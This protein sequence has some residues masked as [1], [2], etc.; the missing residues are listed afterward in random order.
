MFLKVAAK[1]AGVELTG[2]EYEAMQKS[3]KAEI[4]D[5]DGTGSDAV[6]AANDASKAK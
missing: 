2:Q 3:V 1:L 6:N 4:V 5:H